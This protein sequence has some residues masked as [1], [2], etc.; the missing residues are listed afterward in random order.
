[1]EFIND[2]ICDEKLR[3]YICASRYILFTYHASSILSSGALVYSLNFCKPIIAPNVGAF[4]DITDVVNCYNSFCDI[5]QMNVVFNHS[6]LHSYIE[7]NTWIQ[8]PAKIMSCLN[9]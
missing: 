9:S 2:F 7:K 6:A 8:F 3:E 1:V 4:K 5:P